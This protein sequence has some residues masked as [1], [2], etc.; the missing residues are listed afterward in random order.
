MAGKQREVRLGNL[1]ARRDWGY[2]PD[3]VEAMWQMLQQPEPDDYVVATGETHSV[4]EFAEMAFSLAGLDYRKY[5]AIDPQLHRP[6]EVDL[7]VGNPAKARARLGWC[8]RTPF[9][10]L[11]RLMVI[12]DLELAGVEPRRDGANSPGL[13]LE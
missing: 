13:R 10:S 1:E 6:A 7:L 11:V 5:V 2:A 9:E 3:Y 12:A 8:S 4:R